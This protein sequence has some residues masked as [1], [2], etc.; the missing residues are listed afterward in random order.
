V[1][2]LRQRYFRTLDVEPTETNEKKLKQALDRAYQQR[3]FEIEHYWKRATYFW[4]FQIAIFA[5]FGLFW[6]AQATDGLNP[7]ILALA[8]LGILTAL[9]NSLSARGSKF[10]QENWENHIDMLED[11]MEGRLYKTVWLSDGK[12]GFSVSRI[13]RRLSDYFVIFWA[14][15]AIFVAWKFVEPPWPSALSCISPAWFY[16][17]ILALVAVIGVFLLLNESSDIQ[18]TLPKVDGSHGAPIR[19]RS[20]WHRRVDESGHELFIRRY[21]PDESAASTDDR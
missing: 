19:R 10:W 7:I 16:V 3:T 20:T 15:A 11:K 5:A 2:N 17:L 8:V 1:S 9:A 6:K 18:G 12:V 21:A 4:G 13:N 14:L